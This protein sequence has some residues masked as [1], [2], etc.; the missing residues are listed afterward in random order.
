MIALSPS[1]S[2]TRPPPVADL[3]DSILKREA[4]RP[5]FLEACTVAERFP[6]E[7][8]SDWRAATA[9][10]QQVNAGLACT[11]AFFVLTTRLGQQGDI[12]TGIAAAQ[13]AETICRRAG[14]RPAAALLESVE[15]LRD[16]AGAGTVAVCAALADLAAQRP[17]AVASAIPALTMVIPVTGAEA[18]AEWLATGLRAYGTDKAKFRAYVALEDPLAR[19]RL[20]EHGRAGALR[21]AVPVAV[22]FAASLNAEKLRVRHVPG[23][24][25]T[26]LAPPVVVM[27]EFYADFSAARQAEIADAALAHAAVHR[28]FGSPERFDP[29]RLKPIQI[30]LTSLV[31]D[32]R[33]EALAIRQWPGLARLWRPFHVATPNSAR[34][35]PAYMA[36]M[37]RALFDADYADADSWIVKARAMFAAEHA[38]LEDPA[39]SR[40]IGNLL[41]NDLGQMRL[42]FNAKAYVVEPVYR[43]DHAGLWTSERPPEEEATEVDVMVEAMRRNEEERSDG[44]P[45]DEPAQSKSQAGRAKSVPLS[46]QDGLVIARLPEWDHAASVERP[47]WVTVKAYRLAATSPDAVERL[48][49]ET[50]ALSKKVTALVTRAQLGLPQRLKRQPE[51]EEIDLDQAISAAI[52][53][54]IG[55]PPDH[56][57]HRRIERRR[58]D[59]ATLLLV[60][61]SESTREKLPGRAKSVL[62]IE[63]MAA[64]V[65]AGAADTLGDRLAVEGFASDGRNDVRIHSVK[66]FREPFDADAMARLAGLKPGFSTRLGGVLRHGGLRFATERAYRR[67]LISITDGEPFDVDCD[68]TL[69]LVEDARK[70]VHDLRAAGIDAFGLGI[71]TAHVSGPRIFGRGN[72][73]P[74]ARVEDLPGALSALYFRLSAR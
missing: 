60:D 34:T 56:R 48:A 51:G 40:K 46:A 50:S 19:Q 2:A 38:R 16:V 15:R 62:D 31:E 28:I 39:L 54:R 6:E 33:V 72:F 12:A 32:A 26:S 30:A 43:D 41:G 10:L 25:R 29:K 4:L 24:V 70:A 64:A 49:S 1:I 14:A 7:T 23:A 3:R 18:Y 53:R 52:A 71:G 13:A 58:R 57:V 74:V 55:E 65:L 8:F 66:D 47:D 35:A 21:R 37:A 67:V 45:R 61:T 17:E 73:M 27:P 5:Y 44:K 20:Q 11:I 9:A 63:I 22:A 69:Y 42:S 36:R 59:A 68:D